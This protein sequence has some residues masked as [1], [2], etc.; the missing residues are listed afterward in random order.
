[1]HVICRYIND[2]EPRV[3]VWVASSSELLEQAAEAF[4]N[5]WRALG[6]RDVSI[7]R[8][9][10][11]YDADFSSLKDGILIAGFQKLYASSNASPLSL[12]QLG[13]RVGLVVIDEAHQAIA[14]SY[15]EVIERIANAG[16]ASGI[17][18][19]S[20]TPGRTWSDVDADE[21][22]ARYFDKHKVVLRAPDGGNPVTFLIQ[23][24]YLAHPKFT[25]IPFR[26]AEC[27]SDE[28]RSSAMKDFDP[29]TLEHVA[30]LADRNAIILGEIER[31]I[32][33][34]HT[35]IILFA[36]SVRHAELLTVALMSLGVHAILLT[37]DTPPPDR[38][39]SIM[40]F[41]GAS[42][43]PMVL[44]NFGVLTTGFDAPRTS[45]AVI[46]RPTRSLVLYSQMVGRAIR[47]P[48]AGG[49]EACE[50]VTIVDTALPGFGDV[51]DAFS[52]WEDVWNV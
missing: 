1:M 49:N 9:W 25:Q 3:V 39:R 34:G 35:R 12:L 51:A 13:S 32:G 19:L 11:Q 30:A 36:A 21:Q 33:D 24:G 8:Y 43:M 38:M 16:I 28:K 26:D 44:C 15:Q 7:Y 29:E 42:D 4:Q 23:N 14:P 52:N 45:A 10:G 2:S 5:A 40:L 50:I 37:A 47:G 6:N 46:V 17:V 18:G 41:R 20:A 31:L 48:A 27:V 22:L